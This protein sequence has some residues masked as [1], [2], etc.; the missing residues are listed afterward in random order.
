MTEYGSD[1]NSSNTVLSQKTFHN[2]EIY[3]IRTIKSFF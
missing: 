1:E 2:N 3:S